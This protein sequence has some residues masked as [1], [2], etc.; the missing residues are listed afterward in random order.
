MADSRLRFL[1]AATWSVIAILG[2]SAA[3]SADYPLPAFIPWILALLAGHRWQV[4]SPSGDRLYLA[5]GVAA[6]V[7]LVVREPTAVVAIF[8]LGAAV[9]W[10]FLAWRRVER[11][12]ASID[13][14]SE[15]VA[16]GALA[17]VWYLVTSLM[18]QARVGDHV[19]PLIALAA[20]GMAWFLVWAMVRAVAGVEREDLSGRYVWLLALED[21]PV[22]V[23]LLASG[24]LFGTVFPVIGWWALPLAIMPYGFSHLAFV[25]YHGTRL[26][27][28]QTIRSLAGIPEVA[29]LAPDG[30][31]I[32]TADLAVTVAKEMGLHPDSVVE[33]EYAALMHDIGRV[34]LNEPAILKA[35]YTDEDIA[36]WGAQI[37]A[38]APYLEQVANLVREQHKPFRRPGEERDPDLPLPA[39]II[40][41]TSAFDQA[42]YEA[43]RR[44][45]EALETL[46]RGAAYEFDPDVVASLRR[47]LIYRGVVSA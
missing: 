40:K 19:A 37:I 22:V 45:L 46:H 29:G 43:G 38:E 32:R 11:R 44:P 2:T 36:R 35:G 26:T 30:H 3:W 7:P 20:A 5:V 1:S 28:G 4:P 15:V 17:L 42:V 23:S 16:L 33:L 25:R 13:F 41:A 18:N 27:Y 39:K 8:A 24:A 34:T 14:L 6:A 12:S 31:A 9:S 10:L 47:V 21:W